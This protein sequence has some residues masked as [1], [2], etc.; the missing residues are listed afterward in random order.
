MSTVRVVWAPAVNLLSSRALRER[1]LPL[2]FR[3]LISTW[4]AT[5]EVRKT[6]ADYAVRLPIGAAAKLHA[7]ADLYPGAGIETIITDLMETALDEIVTAMP[8][9]PGE[10]V[11]SE[12]DHGD[13]VYEDAGPTPRFEQLR[14]QHEQRLSESAND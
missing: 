14:R 4:E 9:V 11:I 7:L 10:H 2:S 3:D 1:S 12:D 13:P 8:Y 5:P 6:N